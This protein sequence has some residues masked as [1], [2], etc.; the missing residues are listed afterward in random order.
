V[1]T[2]AAVTN[3]SSVP[4]ETEILLRND[5]TRDLFTLRL[6]LSDPA[7][8]AAYR[9]APGQF[10]M[11]YLPGVGGVPISIASDPDTP[12]VLDHTIRAVGRVTR[13]LAQLG[14][15]DRL[16]LRGPYGRGWPLQD[17]EGKDLVMLT[18]GL[19]CAPVVAAIDYAIAR[20]ERF[21]RLVILQG[22]KHAADL[23]WR[24]RYDAWDALPDTQVRLAADQAD[25]QWPG[26][27]GLVTDLLDQVSFDAADAIAMLCGPELMMRAGARRLAELGVPAERIWLSLERGFR[28]G[29]GHCGHCQLGPWFVCRDGPVLRW[30][31]IGWL[32]GTEGF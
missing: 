25:R 22:V 17:A 26:H 12:E 21:G 15:G 28:C 11:L 6:C 18:G 23:I 27:V 14:P 1:T 31:D 30:A 13:A 32:L 9:F 8:R 16:G 10:N 19:G 5:E 4:W 29:I 3:P 2:A 24:A 7:T 20:R